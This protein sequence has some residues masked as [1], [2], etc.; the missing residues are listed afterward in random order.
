MQDE[1][2]SVIK[3]LERQLCEV[4]KRHGDRG[5]TEQSE[6]LAQLERNNA[7]SESKIKHLINQNTELKASLDKEVST[8][9]V[10]V[11][12]ISTLKVLVSSKQDDNENLTTKISE[13][14]TLNEKNMS[15][16][17]NLILQKS[18]ITQDSS[19]MSNDIQGLSQELTSL[20]QLN[21]EKDCIIKKFN[22]QLP[23]FDRTRTRHFL[24]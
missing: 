9:R 13:L 17:E 16:I 3:N 10:L 5:S 15:R 21:V 22:S 24:I 6:L 4:N 11:Q 8:N 1:K 19:N 7:I 23:K 14:R 18:Q 20:K 2:E 12:E